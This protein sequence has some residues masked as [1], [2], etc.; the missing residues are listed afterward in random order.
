MPKLP[1]VSVA[2]VIRALG[3]LGFEQVRQRGSHVVL[4]RTIPTG[5]KGA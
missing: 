3:K 5:V 1:R 2:E 4:R